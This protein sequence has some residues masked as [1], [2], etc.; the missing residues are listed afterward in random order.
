MTAATTAA[1]M[2]GGQAVGDWRDLAV[3]RD[4][5]PDLFFPAAESGPVF[6]A[7]VAA[8]KAVCA[9]CPVRAE[10]LRFALAALPFGVA[11]GLTEDERRQYRARTGQAPLAAP[12]AGPPVGASRPEA[13]AA[14]QAALRAGRPTREVA[15]QCGVTERT[16][17]RWAAQLRDETDQDMGSDGGAGSAAEQGRGVA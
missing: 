14:G 15:Q 17:E 8:A 7:Q 13:A 12:A 11:G 3:C 10:C 2:A 4:V 16:A 1:A 6:D 5:G 9:G